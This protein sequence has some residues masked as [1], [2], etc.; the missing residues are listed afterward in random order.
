MKRPRG[1]VQIPVKLARPVLTDRQKIEII[2]STC[3][4]A[5]DTIT[6]AEALSWIAGLLGGRLLAGVAVG[7][8]RRGKKVGGLSALARLIRKGKS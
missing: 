1:N 2:R 8:R 3:A 7:R 5:G 6:D 4:S